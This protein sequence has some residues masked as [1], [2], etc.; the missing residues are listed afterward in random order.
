MSDLKSDLLSAQSLHA[1]LLKLSDAI[2]DLASAEI[3]PTALELLKNRLGLSQAQI[4]QRTTQGDSI[5][6]QN[7]HPSNSFSE[8][9][10][11]DKDQYKSLE[12]DQYLTYSSGLYL[13]LVKDGQLLQVLV[14]DTPAPRLWED[15][16]IEL[17][18]QTLQRSWQTKLRAQK[19]EFLSDSEEKHRMLFQFM[20][21]G[22]CIIEMIYDEHG[23]PVDWRYLQVNH[24][25]ERHNGLKDAQGRT[26]KEMTPNIEDKWMY[27]YDSV[28]K[29]GKPIR[30]EEDSTA[31]SRVFNLYA[32][33]MDGG[34][35]HVAVIFTDITRQRQA[36]TLLQAAQ[37]NYR[38]TMEIEVAKRTA[39]LEASK[40][41]LQSVFDTTLVQLSILE[42]IRAPNE[43]IEDFEIK[44]VNRELER[45]T[46]KTDLMGKR[47]SEA[48]P[49][50]R[51]TGL[52]E[53]IAKAVDTG[54]P[55][56]TEYCYPEGDPYQWY[57]CMFVSSGENVVASYQNITTKKQAEQEQY[58]NHLLLRQSEQ[59]A[60]LGSWDYDLNNQQL[61]WSEGMYELFGTTSE[62]K[63]NLTNYFNYA[64]EQSRTKA[65]QL[66]EAIQNGHPSFKE[67]LQL[68]ING[69]HKI[70]Q[71]QTQLITDEK[72][73]P[74]RVLGTDIDITAAHSAQEKL[75]QLEAERHREIVR[76]TFS[77]LE[78]ERKR[79]SESL[80]NG[81]AQI[82]YGVKISLHALSQKDKPEAFT[83]QLTY[84][85]ELLSEAI[86][87][88]RRISHELMPP[89]LEEFGLS[90]S[91]RDIVKKLQNQVKF[92]YR[93]S[94]I[95]SPLEKYIKLAIY[96]TVQELMMNIVKHANA[97]E[98]L[99]EV[100]IKS[101]SIGIHVS[102]NG[103]GMPKQKT[104]HHGI[105]L[106]SIRSKIK[107]LNGYMDIQSGKSGT[108]IKIKF[109]IG[110]MD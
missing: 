3:M 48:F 70:I 20:D 59:L 19:L 33:R 46:G 61:H 86:A 11:L 92:T 84:A 47:Y 93:I 28:A 37:E 43:L 62:S 67:V 77:T 68:Q 5:E 52:I 85:T 23:A 65:K 89:I 81:L 42:A 21:E 78:E 31:L 30:F 94:G 80:H 57:A 8:V 88:N 72:G 36:E 39:E 109:P 32:F 90:E 79:I 38:N 106:A 55:Q 51:K 17:S 73:R 50:I 7:N 29:T 12:S 110:Q 35:G 100:A 105:C 44:L 15:E 49:S 64:T 95:P 53:I 87:E 98:A 104:S 22:Y 82:L 26:I 25:F 54:V 91:I 96:R 27:I 45:E 34:Q 2:Q 56:Q 71:I 75:K 1:Y 76:I 101:K 103:S 14:I 102:D 74:E 9:L 40:A 4:Y 69:K 63:T 60:L 58:K 66:I 108:H 41:Q 10:K 97:T 83:S 107:L 6:L 13:P 24:A 99:V 18:K 16:E